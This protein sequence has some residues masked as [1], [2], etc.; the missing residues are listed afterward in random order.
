MKRNIFFIFILIPLVFQAQSKKLKL[1]EAIKLGQEQSRSLKISQSKIA[2]ADAKYVELKDMVLPSLNVSAGY[3]RLSDITPFAFQI[4]PNTKPIVFFPTLVNDYTSR[5]SINESVFNG[6]RLKNGLMSQQY[7]LE[8][9]KLDY[10]KDKSEI[11]YNIIN[12]YYNLYKIQASKLLIQQTLAQADER[13]KEIENMEKQGLA[14][15]NDVLRAQ[16]QRSNIELSEVD[17]NSNL[18]IANYNFSVMTGL[19]EGTQIEIDSVDLFKARDFK[20]FPDY[21]QTSFDKR[22]DLKAADFRKKASEMNLKVVKGTILPTVNV[23][24]NYYYANPNPRY[25][26]PADVFHDTWD[27]GINLNWNLTSL[28]TTKHQANEA[29]FMIDQATEMNDLLSD[30]IRMEVNQDF[31]NYKESQKKIEVASRSVVQ[32]AENSRTLQS[33]YDNNTALLSDVLDANVLLL[34]AKLN[35]T[36]ARADAEIAYNHLLKST[37]SN[38]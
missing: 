22:S 30:N 25:I 38:Q 7:L 24:A 17:I 12:A 20:K 3:S 21:L 13:I 1:D 5:A 10:E 19:P 6:F 33:K 4:A 31:V 18:Q 9:S 36:Y 35:L 15:H 11:I 16:L 14:I 8:A 37:G 34:Q 2:I 27:V 23:G 26:P 29:K 32:A 28:Y